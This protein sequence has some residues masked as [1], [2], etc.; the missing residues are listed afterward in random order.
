MDRVKPRNPRLTQRQMFGQLTDHGIAP[1]GP[2]KLATDVSTNL[3]IQLDQ[4]SIHRLNRLLP[5]T[6]N[7][8]KDFI[9]AI[10]GGVTGR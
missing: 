1:F 8:R 2:F 9:E 5:G 7:Q 3:P 10:I 6:V 4:L